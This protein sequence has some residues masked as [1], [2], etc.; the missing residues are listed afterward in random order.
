MSIQSK[1]QLEKYQYGTHVLLGRQFYGMSGK[2]LYFGQWTFKDPD[3]IIIVEMNEEI[4]ER[5]ASFYRDLNGH[6]N[7]IRTFGYV[8]NI[9]NS[10]IFVQEY[11]QQGDLANWLMDNQ[12]DLS[13]TLSIE[14]FC[15]VADAM[16]YVASKSIVHGDLGCRNILVYRIDSSKPENTLVKI[17][18]F[19][20]AH[21]IDHP[22]VNNN[23]SIVPI[24]FCA[25]EILENNVHINYSEKSD[26]YSMGVLMWEALSNGEMPF[27]SIFSDDTVKRMKLNNE[28][29]SQPLNCDRQ[30]WIL[31]EKCWSFNPKQRFNF[32]QIKDELSEIKIC[33]P[34]NIQ[35]SILTYQSSPISYDFTLNIDVA[36]NK[37]LDGSYGKVYEGQWL[38]KQERPI[39]LIKIDKQITEYEYLFYTEFKS[40]PHII[41][42]FGFVENDLQSILLLQERAPY[43]N[44]QV[45]I[46]NHQFQPST[47]VLMEIFLQIIDA[48][49][50]ITQQNIIHGDL[51]CSNVLVFEMNES[52]PNENL[53]KLTN[54]TSAH[55]NNPSAEKH[56]RSKI[57]IRYCALEILRSAGRS[58]YSELSDV[59]SMGVLMWQTCS[60]G[61]LPYYTSTLNSEVRQRKLN[62]E[63]LIKPL[64][65]NNQIWSIM[66]DCWH[67]EPQLRFNFEDM[68]IRLSQVNLKSEKTFQYKMNVNVKM[69]N[70]LY[71]KFGKKFYE[72]EFI[73]NND[74]SI[75]LVVMNEET[76]RQEV[77]FYLQLN[78][79]SHIVHT[80]GLVKYDPRSTTLVQERTHYGNL[81]AVL[82]SHQFR[83]SENVLIKIFLQIID[84]MIYIVNQN[85]IH[86]DL[87][88]SNILVFQMNS[89]KPEENLVKLTNFNLTRMNDP[90]FIGK[91][92]TI[93]PIRYCAPEI[94]RNE[95]QSNYSEL[96]D[97]YSMGVLMWEAY[98]KGSIPFQSYI[99]DDD[100][101]QCRLNNEKLSK[102][103]ECSQKV[104]NIIHDCWYLEPELRYNFTDM[105]YRISNAQIISP[106]NE[107]QYLTNDI[108]E[109]SVKQNFVEANS[110][111]SILTATSSKY[112]NKSCNLS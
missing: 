78:S 72:G 19:G 62:G 110:S 58:N 103:N 48:M 111:S 30:I 43:G 25:P 47:K 80:F 77:P 93:F 9:L 35:Q 70:Q 108:S 56:K 105:Q 40:H 81:Q 109:H 68:K 100:I 55:E 67:N 6:N 12:T 8:E 45:L 98:S 24:R 16:S 53:V 15:Q 4:T 32:E 60:N 82:C 101:R 85:I 96:S 107:N 94:L 64:V 83:P 31:M 89:F 74:K 92:Q 66:E 99:N 84:A 11:A 51:C 21:S 73:P 39:V 65:C 52:K 104:W 26:V 36:M 76:A 69:G 71:D 95:N 18:D 88:C 90:S 23:S 112:V 41:H 46:E 63:K 97:V 57:P 20:L 7:I 14:I 42:T 79:H 22:P 2:K 38:L 106:Q 34:S 37:S 3:P 49:I 102:P 13:S 17:T 5:E 44:L 33:E 59:Y 87:C 10:T 29:L 50:Y 28:R 75:I 86:G 54:F 61:Q 1:L 91:K 27:S